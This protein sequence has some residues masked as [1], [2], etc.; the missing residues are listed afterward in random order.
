MIDNDFCISYG[1]FFVCGDQVVEA[2]GEV[3]HMDLPMSSVAIS[4]LIS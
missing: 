4:W 1:S 2:V 3:I